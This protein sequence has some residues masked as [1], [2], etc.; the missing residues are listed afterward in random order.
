MRS[1]DSTFF[2]PMDDH[3]EIDDPSKNPVLKK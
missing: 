2:Q 3:V 1:K